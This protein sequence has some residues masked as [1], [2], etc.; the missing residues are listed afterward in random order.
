MITGIGRLKLSRAYESQRHG[1]FGGFAH[2][3]DC[4]APL[5]MWEEK[6]YECYPGSKKEMPDMYEVA[7]GKD[8]RKL[9]DSRA[10]RQSKFRR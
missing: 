2:C 6:C 10:Y 1:F 5:A 9:E 3:L 7:L 4:G 8:L